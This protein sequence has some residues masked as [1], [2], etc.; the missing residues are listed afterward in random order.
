MNILHGGRMTFLR[1]LDSNNKPVSC[2]E[3]NRSHCGTFVPGGLLQTLELHRSQHLHPQ[4]QSHL[5]QDELQLANTCTE[6][7]DVTA[8]YKQMIIYIIMINILIIITIIYMIISI[9]MMIIIIIWITFII[10]YYDT[11]Y[12]KNNMMFFIL[13]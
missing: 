7:R 2:K 4:D 3:A 6:T 9:I 1:F 8:S 12:H 13:F 11:Y 5:Q 10:H